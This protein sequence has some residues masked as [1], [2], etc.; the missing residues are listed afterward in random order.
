MMTGV[1]TL[2]YLTGN[3]EFDASNL[4][5]TF[6]IRYIL[7]SINKISHTKTGRNK[8]LATM[9]SIMTAN[10]SWRNQVNKKTTLQL[11][12]TDCDLT[13]IRKTHGLSENH[14]WMVGL[15]H[16]SW[17]KLEATLVLPNT[18]TRITLWFLQQVACHLG[19]LPAIF[20]DTGGNSLVL[21]D[22][23][24][25]CWCSLLSK[26]YYGKMAGNLILHSWPFR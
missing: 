4:V 26:R 22:L 16:I 10:P 9:P 14:L 3:S 5:S 1:W 17:Q 13:Q 23:W 21:W 24:D 6:H 11:G 20:D 2:P 18:M 12:L 19:D 25:L 15:P 8:P 7:C